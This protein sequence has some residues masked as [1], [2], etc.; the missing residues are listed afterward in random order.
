ME[1]VETNMHKWREGSARGHPQLLTTVSTVFPLGKGYWGIRK[2]GS[3]ED[4]EIEKP[5]GIQR[6]CK[7][8]LNRCIN[9]KIS[10][11]NRMRN[12]ILHNLKISP[13]RYLSVNEIPSLLLV[14]EGKRQI[15]MLSC[16]FFF[17]LHVFI[18]LERERAR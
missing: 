2:T 13:L 3:G 14:S 8:E 6:P 15:R 9:T 4:H 16:E 17:T 5:K 1:Q 18:Y 12:K 7:S 10:E 11:K